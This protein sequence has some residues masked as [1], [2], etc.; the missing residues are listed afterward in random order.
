MKSRTPRPPIEF[1]ICD[2]VTDRYPERMDAAGWTTITRAELSKFLD[3]RVKS[4]IAPHEFHC[5]VLPMLVQNG[6]CKEVPRKRRRPAIGFRKPG[7]DWLTQRL[8]AV[9][10]LHLRAVNDYNAT[11]TKDNQLAK[12]L[13]GERANRLRLELSALR[14]LVRKR[15]DEATMP[16][17]AMGQAAGAV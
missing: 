13:A 4:N 7:L 1:L 8:S 15:L 12:R 6:F 3:C 5:R 9:E 17:K 10:D 11:P 16:T 2:L 14:L